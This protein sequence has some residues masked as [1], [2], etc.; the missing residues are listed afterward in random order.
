MYA[1]LHRC[2]YTDH[3]MHRL[4]REKESSGDI[5][6]RSKLM[7]RLEQVDAARKQN[8]FSLALRLLKST[9]AVR[10]IILQCSLDGMTV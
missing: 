10:L 2:V 9:R 8:I 1:I 6:E 3:L 7:F 5:F 4:K